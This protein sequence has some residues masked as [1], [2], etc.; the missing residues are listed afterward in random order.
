M[1]NKK[2]FCLK[3]IAHGYVLDPSINDINTNG[4]VCQTS[5]SHLTLVAF[6]QPGE[7]LLVADSKG[8]VTLVELGQCLRYCRI[9]RV[10]SC[11]FVAFNPANKAEMLV[12]ST[13][14]DVRIIKMYGNEK[15]DCTLKGHKFPVTDTSSYKNHILTSSIKE[16]IIWDLS[17]CT[18]VHQLRFTTINVSLR[19]AGFSST[20]SVAALYRDSTLQVW[21]FRKLE[22]D[23]KIDPKSLGLQV[24]KDYEFTRDGRAMILA[25]IPNVILILNTFKWDLIKRLQL[26]DSMASVKELGVVPQPLDGGANKILAILTAKLHLH[27]LDLST[28]CV[29]PLTSKEPIV[30]VTRTC[31][32]PNGRYVAYIDV[33]GSLRLEVADTLL[34]IGSNPKQKIE[35]ASQSRRSHGAEEHLRCVR[36]YIKEE[37]SMERLIPILK[38]FGEYPKKHRALIW[39]SILELPRNRNAYAAL[40]N[41]SPQ[42]GFMERILAEYP[43]ADK[44]KALFLATIVN[45]LVHWCPLL[46]ETT[47]LPRFVFPFLIVFQV[48]IFLTGVQIH[49]FDNQRVSEG[50]MIQFLFQGNHVLAFEIVIFLLSNYCQRWFEYHPLPPLNVLAMLENVLSEADP[51]LLTFFCERGVTSSEYVWPLLQTSM[52]EVL[53][54]DEWLI[55]WDH[56]MSSGRPFLLL[57]SSLA[58]SI[59]SRQAIMSRLKSTD[60]F[61]RFYHAQGHVRVADLLRVARRLDRN[62]PYHLHPA[63][64]FK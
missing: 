18:K 2:W 19:K 58:Y 54:G 31:I 16:V 55:L 50:I 21:D 30:G 24:V 33:T 39:T 29:V 15:D 38:E 23:V 11:T 1:D 47:F 46:S 7:R 37:L 36:K 26:P 9:R 20:G 61:T 17:T 62:T 64:Y 52:S 44:S 57:M 48:V 35:G 28:S 42:P 10:M 41:K 32:S 49:T 3:K 60:D 43:L 4:G 59:C 56:I 14:G 5:K 27:I 53:S 45:C 22:Q 63:R 34:S 6:D 40:S 51:Q 25:G 13:N 8:F 12:G